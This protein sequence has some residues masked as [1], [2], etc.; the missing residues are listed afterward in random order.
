MLF[1]QNVSLHRT[2]QLRSVRCCGISLCYMVCKSSEISVGVGGVGSSEFYWLCTA[3]V[4]FT[5]TALPL[6]GKNGSFGIQ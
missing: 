3:N 4:D 5:P 1:V 2:I 6:V